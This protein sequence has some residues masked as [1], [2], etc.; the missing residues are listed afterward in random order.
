M[1]DLHKETSVLRSWVNIFLMLLMILGVGVFAFALIGDLGQPDWNYG[2]I[3]DVPAESPYA[4][5]EPLDH[6]QH[7]RG[8]QGE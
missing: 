8:A 1:A 3:P 4:I 5:Y 7:V 2:T 6:P